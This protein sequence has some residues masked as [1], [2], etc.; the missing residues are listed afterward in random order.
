MAAGSALKSKL[1]RLKEILQ[2]LDSVLV[3]YSGGVDSTLLLKCAVDVLGYEKVVA[4]TAV[5]EIMIQEDIEEAKK[6]A[7]GLGVRHIIFHSEE[8]ENLEFIANTPER[9]YI[10]KKGR[11]ESLVGLKEELGLAYIVDGSNKDDEKDYRPGERALKELGI[12]SP[13]REAGLYKSEI[14]EISREM[15]LPTWDSPSRT[16]LATRIP[17]GES[18]TKDKIYAIREAENLLHCMGFAQVRVRHHGDI[19][20][21]EVPYDEIDDILKHKKDIVDGIKKLGFKYISLDLEGF[22]SG[23]LNE[24]LKGQ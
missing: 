14:R 2:E 11:Y 21:I 9:C 18:I 23:S 24:V 1:M 6:V 8:M 15:G 19:A 3:A 13:L 20:R 7:E 12:R 10:C 4:A 22:R 5:S 16:C 17:Y